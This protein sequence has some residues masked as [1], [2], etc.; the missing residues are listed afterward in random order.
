MGDRALQQVALDDRVD[1]ALALGFGRRDVAAR[2]HGV[3]RVLRAGETRQALG[4][5]GARQ[6]AKMHFRQAHARG[7]ERNAIVRPQRRLEAAAQRRAMQGRHDQLGR[8]LHGR[9]HVVQVR[10][11]RRLAELADVGAGDEGPA[12]ADQDDGVD[13][14]ILAERLD[15]LLDAGAD[16]RGQRVHRRIV[17]GEDSDAPLF[18]AYDSVGH[19]RSSLVRPVSDGWS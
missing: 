7:R 18:G 12:A 10:P 16:G 15:A 8:I 1:D 11:R 19:G 2:E 14:G 3:E 17:D 13:A 4:A 5:A 6:E 9:D